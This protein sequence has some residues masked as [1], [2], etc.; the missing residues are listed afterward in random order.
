MN[1]VLESKKHRLISHLSYSQ[2]GG[3]GL[4]FFSGAIL[5]IPQKSDDLYVEVENSKVPLPDYFEVD[6]VPIVNQR[7]VDTISHI[8]VDNY[9]ALPIEIRFT[10]EIEKSYYLLNVIG[11]SKCFDLE[12]T[13]C[14]KFGPSV[15]RVFSLKLQINPANGAN[16]FRAHEYQ[17]VIFV[18]E[19]VKA[20]IEKKNITGCELRDADGWTDAHRF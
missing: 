17:E 2:G 8:G 19:Q 16:M 5:D 14:S 18:S 3:W 13:D 4:D 11:R 20:E 1:Y 9:Q 6:G 10:N 12:K 7:F 15:A